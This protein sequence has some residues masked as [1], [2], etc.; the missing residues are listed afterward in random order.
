M[1]AMTDTGDPAV[2]TGTEDTAATTD[3]GDPALTTDIEDSA[4]TT[5]IG[6]TISAM[7]TVGTADTEATITFMVALCSE[8]R[9]PAQLG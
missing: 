4:A 9:V 2:T 6:D 3:I 5:D 1:P 8:T 7:S